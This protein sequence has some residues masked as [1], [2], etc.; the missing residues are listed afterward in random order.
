M[1]FLHLAF[2]QH[3]FLTLCS[4]SAYR[5]VYICRDPKD[6]LVSKWHFANKLRTKELPPLSLE[7]TFDLFCK[8]VSH[9]GLFWNHVL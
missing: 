7:E 8:G 1:G 2:F 6:V 9:Y 5:L 4:T 3:T